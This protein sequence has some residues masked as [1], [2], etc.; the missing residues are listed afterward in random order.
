MPV[1]CLY[2]HGITVATSALLRSHI[3][4]ATVLLHPETAKKL[5]VAAGEQVE[6][7]GYPAEVRI[8]ATVPASVAL[9]PR[10]SGFPI[11][12]PAVAG[13]KKA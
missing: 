3:R 9:L 4:E 8:D 6:V 2:D 7:N 10:G 5:G 11:N 1:T 13:L 12:A